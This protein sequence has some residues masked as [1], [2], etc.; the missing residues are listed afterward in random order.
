MAVYKRKDVKSRGWF[1]K[2]TI[3]GVTYKKAIPT[4]RTRRQAE[5]AERE[6]L[7]D[8]HNGTYGIRPDIVFNEF[9]DKHYVPYAEKHHRR[10]CNLKYN[11]KCLK[12]FFGSY[13]LRQISPLLIEKFKLQYFKTKTKLKTERKASTVN[14]ILI[15]LSGVLTR[16]VS[17]EYLKE[18]PCHKV[19]HLP[20]E[21]TKIRT[22]S[23]DEE[24][25]LMESL[26]ESP[27]YMKPIVQLALWLGWRQNEIVHLRKCDID[28]ARN[29]VFI[30]RAKWDRDPRKTQGV[31]M[32]GK[33]R[34]LL[35]ELVSEAT[36]DNLFEGPYS[37]KP[38]TASGI[39]HHFKAACDRVGIKGLRFHDLRHTFGTRL[40]EDGVGIEKIARAMGHSSITTTAIYV[41]TS[42]EALQVVMDKAAKDVSLGTVIVPLKKRD[43]G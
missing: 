24:K 41:H 28:F 31:P 11:L 13:T 22:L 35:S 37:G 8:L 7:N 27:A 6:A 26:D 40:G 43:V 17:E 33:V 38:L 15:L 9:V 4:A 42:Q 16:A 1:Y 2:F 29:R 25:L 21:Q 34:N 10:V 5:D 30:P 18:N 32:S 23:G 12:A 14:A 3:N 39:V 36:T 19:K 20:M